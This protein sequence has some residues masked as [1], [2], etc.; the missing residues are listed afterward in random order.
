MSTFYWYATVLLFQNLHIERLGE[1][2]EFLVY[3]FVFF[4]QDNHRPVM[5][6]LK[7]KMTSKYAIKATHTNGLFYC[8]EVEKSAKVSTNNH[9]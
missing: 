1:I 9:H 6:W 8:R 3:L 4:T 7:T 5:Q 2:K